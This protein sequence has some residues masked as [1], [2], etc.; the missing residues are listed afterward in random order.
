MA[1]QAWSVAAADVDIECDSISNYYQ[2]RMYCIIKALHTR[3]DH[4]RLHFA[5]S[6]L[7]D[8]K[9]ELVFDMC[10]MHAIPAGIFVHFPNLRTM[11]TWNSGLQVLRPQDFRNADALRDID[12]SQNNISA[13]VNSM[14]SGAIDLEYIN[15]AH[16]RIDVLPKLTFHGLVR[17]K[18]LRMDHNRIEHLYAGMF[19]VTPKLRMLYAN[20]NRI[21][22]VAG[23]LFVR[24]APLKELHLHCNR[25]RSLNGSAMTHLRQLDHF[26]IDNNPV[27]WLDYLHVD[28]VHT[29]IRNISAAGCL[30]GART[31]T[32]LA[33]ENRIAYVI[34]ANS[35]SVR[36][37]DLHSNRLRSFRNLTVL[38]G[39][40]QLDISENDFRDL[41]VRSFAHMSSL[42]D[43]RLRRS[44]LGA[45]EF[46]ML[47]HKPELR[48]LDLSHNRLG[49]VL[50][51]KFTGLHSVRA[52]FLEGN[53]LHQIDLT[54]VRQYFPVLSTI[55]MAQN[56]WNC[57]NLAIAMKVM[58]ANQIA[59][60]SVGLTR[61][62]TNIR[63]I[64]CETYPVA[65]TVGSTTV[66]SVIETTS[67]GMADG[68]NDGT[69]VRGKSNDSTTYTTISPDS[70]TIPSVSTT[71]FMGTRNGLAI[72]QPIN[73]DGNDNGHEQEN[74]VDGSDNRSVDG[75]SGPI[76][77]IGFVAV[78]D[79]DIFEQLVA[80][81]LE[82]MQA[83]ESAN[84]VVAALQKLL[85]NWSNAS[86][87]KND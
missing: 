24:N 67:A 1:L 69:A 17:L 74:I 16:N 58:D 70:V 73:G 8:I 55:G 56:P 26:R 29:D 59:L 63:G 6:L 60:N 75:V 36:R 77:R 11:Y 42:V 45:I 2:G 13:L 20:H 43:L 4:D 28:S 38:H 33:S 81:R 21:R 50:L 44:G 85:D 25:I 10:R 76:T 41:D 34:V 32:L 68:W 39:L 84:R 82:A 40:E 66:A 48:W 53:Q 64:P 37:L 3:G 30:I 5:P 27:E 79:S 49:I 35:S 80:L 71:E 14:F 23:H 22:A 31:Q 51:N 7:A 86:R 87:G 61:E 83:A 15:L 52:L 65:L 78:T 57:T 72:G 9:R 62:S 54:S 47:S 12:L 18:V 46:G 19:D